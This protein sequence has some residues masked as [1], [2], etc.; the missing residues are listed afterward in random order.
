MNLVTPFGEIEILIDGKAIEYNYK[1]LNPDSHCKDVNGRHLIQVS[2]VPDGKNHR[3]SCRIS[4]YKASG[5]DEIET[6]ENL[7]LK[8]FYKGNAK[9]SIGMEGDSGYIN[10]ERVSLFY[11]YDNDYQD[12]GVEYVVLPDTKTQNYV[13]GI[14]WLNCCHENND[15]QTWFG[16]D[17][18]IMKF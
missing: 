5:S 7:E 18:T 9:L 17:P 15:V 10:G 16:A 8:S 1:K 11:D 13:F 12:D 14:S 6:G 4:G 3:I 2:F